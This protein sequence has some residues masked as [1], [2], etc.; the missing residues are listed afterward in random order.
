[1]REE[2]SLF[3]IRALML[4]AIIAPLTVVLIYIGSSDTVSVHVRNESEMPLQNLILS[5]PGL[6]G[7]G[8]GRTEDLLP[9]QSE[10]PTAVDIRVKFPFRLEFDAAGQH[11][12]VPAQFRFVPLGSY[13]LFVTVGPQMQVSF[14]TV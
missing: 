8:V 11:H 9:G 10:G 12:D 13:A 3:S 6:G 2:V 7:S 14:R 1:M 4:L 5:L